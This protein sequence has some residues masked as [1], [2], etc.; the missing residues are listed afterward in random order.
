LLTFEHPH[1]PVAKGGSMPGFDDV[2][3][4][5]KPVI[6]AIDGYCMAG[7]MERSVM[8]HLLD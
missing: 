1:P 8:R 7:G 4:C 6:A 3:N 2:D 5:S